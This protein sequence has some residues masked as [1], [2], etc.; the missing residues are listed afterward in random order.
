MA[1]HNFNNSLPNKFVAS[2]VKMAV[3]VQVHM[4]SVLLYVY[5]MHLL[6]F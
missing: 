3:Y 6:C 4:Y 1:V 5:R 2:Y